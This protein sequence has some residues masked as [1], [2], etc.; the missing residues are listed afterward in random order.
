MRVVRWFDEHFEET[1]LVLLLVA[2]SCVMMLQIIM[3]KVVNS[4][5]PWPEEFCRYCYVWTTFFTLA[6]AMRQGNMLRVS[7]VVDLFPKI[8]RKIVYILGNLACLA[9]FT[10]FF[11]NSID[12]VQSIKASGQ[13]STAMGL[14]MYLVYLSTVIGFGLGAVRTVQ[15]IYKQV[16]NFNVQEQTM[17]EAVMEEA[18]SEVALA[19]ADLKKESERE[20]GGSA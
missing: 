10:V 17:I 7:V 18:E 2:I 1:V 8:A 11:F 6:F 16:K 20:G 3:R 19:A 9:F 13:S 12:V 4:S 14:P 5:L 15:V